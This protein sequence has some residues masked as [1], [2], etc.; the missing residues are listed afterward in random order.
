MDRKGPVD[1]VVRWIVNKLDEVGYRGEAITLKSDQERSIVAL[2]TAVAASRLG[3][4]T[5]IESPVRES[6]CNGAVEQAVRRWQGQLRT[7]KGH[8]E[9]NM[10]KK[11]PVAHPLMGW[12]V[13]WAGEI[14]LKYKV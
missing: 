1:W 10:G 4:T 9:A 12:L 8:F 11:L 6:Q 5:P 2:K 13:I 7:L 3:A 14:L